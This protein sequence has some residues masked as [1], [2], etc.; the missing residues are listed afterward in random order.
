LTFVYI[1]SEVNDGGWKQSSAEQRAL[2]RAFGEYYKTGHWEWAT[3]MVTKLPCD[4]RDAHYPNLCWHYQI[5][6]EPA[7]G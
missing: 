7:D 5:E 6:I 3:L 2:D 1:S 4:D